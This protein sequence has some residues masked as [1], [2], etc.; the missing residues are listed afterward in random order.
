MA[1]TYTRLTASA[2]LNVRPTCYA[3]LGL[4]PSMAEVRLCVICDDPISPERIA[5]SPTAITCNREHSEEHRRWLQRRNARE[6]QRRLRKEGALDA[7]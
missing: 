7:D 1:A 4:P 6:R 2:R 3:V 5:V